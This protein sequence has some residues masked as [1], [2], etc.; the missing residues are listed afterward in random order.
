MDFLCIVKTRIE[1]QNS[2]NRR[3]KYQRPYPNQDQDAKPLPTSSKAPNE[4]LKKDMDVLCTFKIKTLSQIR[5]KGV[6]KTSEHIKIKIKMPNLSE[7]TLVSSKASNQD[8]K[9]MDVLCTFKSRQGAKLLNPGVSKTSYHIQ[10]NINIPTPSQKPPA[11]SKAQNKSL[12]NMGVL[13]TFRIKIETQ[14]LEGRSTN[15][16]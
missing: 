9:D 13:C 6:S 16:Q 2:E 8:L 7:E 1:R 10:I 15:D 5:I 11:S 3:I 12:K 4:D 14:N